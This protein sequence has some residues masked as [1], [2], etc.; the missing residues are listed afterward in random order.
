M[1]AA[2]TELHQAE[3]GTVTAPGKRSTFIATV[4]M[5]AAALT[6]PAPA[7]ADKTDDI[8]L[9]YI[10][11]LKA[12]GISIPNR[13]AAIAMGHTVCVAL[14]QRPNAKRCDAGPL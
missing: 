1:Q 6:T 11:A 5:A 7:F 10:P 14:G 12:G 3:R 9:A 8:Y 2:V 4:K 13:D